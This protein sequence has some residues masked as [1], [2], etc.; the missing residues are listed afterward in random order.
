[1]NVANVFRD[2]SFFKVMQ[3]S[4]KM[5]TATMTLAPGKA[6]AKFGNEHPRSE[7]VLLVLEG[8]IL[9]EIGDEKTTLR[10]GDVAIVPPGVDHRFVN[11]AE[12]P[13]LT[14]NVYAPPAY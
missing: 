12:S 2:K 1:M 4:K 14:F 7:Q 11:H 13:A 10:K 8:E 3:T 5:Q 9:A 6:S